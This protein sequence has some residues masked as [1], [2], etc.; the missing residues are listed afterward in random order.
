[1]MTVFPV[2]T[3]EVTI[4]NMPPQ[5]LI[6]WH[7]SAWRTCDKTCEPSTLVSFTH[8]AEKV[9]VSLVE[10]K[11]L[12]TCYVTCLVENAIAQPRI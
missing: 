8:K 3:L 1:M 6:M 11:V 5:A 9:S 10:V 7:A 12:G 4:I 2:A